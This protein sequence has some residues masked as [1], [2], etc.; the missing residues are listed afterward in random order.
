MVQPVIDYGATVWGVNEY[1]HIMTIQHRA[2]Q[3]FLGFGRY[4]PNNAVVGEMGWNHPSE[5]LW[6]CVFRQWRRLS[7]MS[8][9]RLNARVH[10]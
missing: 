3:Y 9:L 7:M 1:S 4:A 2:G 8:E 6:E 10:T 5:H